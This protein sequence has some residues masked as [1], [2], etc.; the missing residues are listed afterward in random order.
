MSANRIVQE[1]GTQRFRDQYEQKAFQ[2]TQLIDL[3]I[4][5]DPEGGV[6]RQNIYNLGTEAYRAKCVY[7]AN[8]YDEYIN[9]ELTS[10]NSETLADVE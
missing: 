2:Y 1:I 6:S 3:G 5:E 9:G 4:I 10:F 8:K 7:F